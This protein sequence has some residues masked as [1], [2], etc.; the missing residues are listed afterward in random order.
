MLRIHEKIRANIAD[1]PKGIP[2]PLII[3]R[4]INDVAIV[5]LTLAAQA[6]SGGALDRQRALSRSPR[7][8]STS[9]PR[10]TTSA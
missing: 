8:C 7:S 10:S 2:E 4:G 3:G 9:W 1:L 5:V 6:G